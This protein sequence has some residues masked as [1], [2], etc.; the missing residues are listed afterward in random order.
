MINC[1]RHTLCQ[2]NHPHQLQRSPQYVC[3]ASSSLIAPLTTVIPCRES[4]TLNSIAEDRNGILRYST[5]RS[6]GCGHTE[7]VRTSHGMLRPC[8]RLGMIVCRL[9]YTMGQEEVRSP[10]ILVCMLSF[11]HGASLFY[12]RVTVIMAHTY[13]HTYIYIGKAK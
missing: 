2:L 8:K 4:L 13:I 9:T 10:I 11:A 7:G 6:A 1:R 3:S 12:N 5:L